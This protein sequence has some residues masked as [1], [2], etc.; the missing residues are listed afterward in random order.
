MPPRV[1]PI[2]PS[3]LCTAPCS[4]LIAFLLYTLIPH[5]SFRP[6]P[7]AS[8]VVPAAGGAACEFPRPS[9]GATPAAR[10]G[11]S[12]PHPLAALLFHESYCF[13]S[14]LSRRPSSGFLLWI[15]KWP[16][17]GMGFVRHILNKKKQTTF[18]STSESLKMEG[19]YCCQI[20]IVLKKN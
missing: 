2:Q 7:V 4:P 11:S 19:R 15:S 3:S 6:S 9:V 17:W 10:W 20:Y 12:P 1:S 18:N 14:P 8:S 13:P 16:V 5:S